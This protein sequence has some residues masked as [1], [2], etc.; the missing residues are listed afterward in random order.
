M[1]ESCYQI[2][3]VEKTATQPQIK[4]A[5]HDLVK[6]WHPDKC[7]G[8]M[9]KMAQQKIAE[10]NKAYEQ[11]GTVRKRME[12]DEKL[13]MEEDENDDQYIMSNNSDSDPFPTSSSSSM[14]SDSESSMDL[15]TFKQ[16]LRDLNEVLRKQGLDEQY[17]TDFDFEESEKEEPEDEYYKEYYEAKRKHELE[18]KRHAEYVMTHERT[19]GPDMEVHLDL[20]LEDIFIGGKKK[21]SGARKITK[22]N[23]ENA[24]ANINIR[25]NIYDSELIVVPK[26]GHYLMENGRIAQDPGNM[27]VY[28][29]IEEHALF[30]R[31]GYDLKAQFEITLDEAQKGFSRTF[32]DLGKKEHTIEVGPLERS[33]YVYTIEGRGLKRFENNYGDILID[34]V[35]VFDVKTQ[36]KNTKEK[37]IKKVASK[38]VSKKDTESDAEEEK[39]AKKGVSKKV[40]KKDTESDAENEKTVVKKLREQIKSKNKN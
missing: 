8:N 21:V 29:H 19:V 18:K 12:Y 34:F 32:I 31:Y 35:I 5:Y 10:I 23:T 9:K 6:K 1:E 39:P 25:P 27:N 20:I 30:K 40:S 26:K 14:S 28:V 24:Y 11:I 3:G 37:P 22:F 7:K 33:D 16:H 36:N 15:E 4:K 2:L 38:K 13:K 17:D